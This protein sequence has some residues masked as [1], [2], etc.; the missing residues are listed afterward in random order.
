[1]TLCLSYDYNCLFNGHMESRNNNHASVCR[2]RHARFHVF[3]FV[4]Q[5]SPRLVGAG[6]GT[7]PPHSY[8]GMPVCDV[9]VMP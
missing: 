6:Y 1:M 2:L 8:R 3:I 7:S 4:F 9:L 5:L